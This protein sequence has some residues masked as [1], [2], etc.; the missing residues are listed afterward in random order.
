[1]AAS[2]IVPS[3]L[4]WAFGW[5]TA[6]FAAGL[7]FYGALVILTYLRLRDASVSNLWLILMIFI[8]HFGPK[9]EIG[10]VALYPSGLISLIPVATGWVARDGRTVPTE[11]H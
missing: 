9:W 2:I 6:A 3:L 5:Q 7:P 1:M 4:S 8:F 11:M 10:A